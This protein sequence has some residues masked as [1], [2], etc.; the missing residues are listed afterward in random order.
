MG[1]RRPWN[2][3][4]GLVAVTGFLIGIVADLHLL[5]LVTKPIPVLLMALAVFSSTGS[6]AGRRTFWG[7]LFCALGDVLLEVSPATFTPGLGAFLVGHLF[8][9]SAFLARS[10]T[11]HLGLLPIFL[12]WGAGVVVHLHNGLAT[13]GMLGPVVLYS[14]AIS[15]M[16]WRAAACW[17]E[18]PR[19]SASRF[20]FFGAVLFAVSDTLIALNRFGDPIDGAPYAIILLYWAGQMGI[21]L[22]A[23]QQEDG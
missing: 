6:V 17:A 14:L 8:Y 3:F 23:L 2:C 11:P 4:V 15:A 9:T 5:R 1:N 18:A 7:L 13:A 12:L 16:M 22:S 19:S 20:G 10:R 21:T